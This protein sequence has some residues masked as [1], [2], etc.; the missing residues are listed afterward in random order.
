MPVSRALRRLLRI[1]DLE[2]EQLRLGLESA[3]GELHQLQNALDVAA[4]LDRK[5]KELVG[6]G[7]LTGEL[8]DRQAG[9]MESYGAQKRTAALVPRI[10]FTESETVRLR[11]AFLDKR[12]ERRQAETLIEEEEARDTV[13]AARKSQNALDEWYRSRQYRASLE[14]DADEKIPAKDD[15]ASSTEIF[16]P[17]D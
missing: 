15:V 17:L 12:V 13:E 10:A 1:R 4:T 6:F 8:T 16:G 3:M 11:Q 9:L 5:G 7:T 14:A 2:E